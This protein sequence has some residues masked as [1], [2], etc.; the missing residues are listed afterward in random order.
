MRERTPPPLA[1]AVPTVLER[2]WPPVR[3]IGAFLVGSFILIWETVA[4][5]QAQPWLVAAGFAALGVAGSGVLQ[6]W[7]LGRLESK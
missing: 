1:P 2:Y 6:R 3:D 5:S 4:E 7:M